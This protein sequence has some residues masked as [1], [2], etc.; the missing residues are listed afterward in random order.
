M[1]NS[2]SMSNYLTF[3]TQVIKFSPTINKNTIFNK[4]S[5]GV[6]LKFLTK[7]LYCINDTKKN[8]FIVVLQSMIFVTPKKNV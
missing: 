8:F 1:N 6:L 3:S 7:T 5:I 2:L 4:R